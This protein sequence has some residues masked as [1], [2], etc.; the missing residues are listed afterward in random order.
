MSTN[1]KQANSETSDVHDPFEH[2]KSFIRQ[3]NLAAN[4]N[5]DDNDKPIQNERNEPTPSRTTILSV[6]DLNYSVKN[7]KFETSAACVVQ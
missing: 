4:D 6:E 5:K 1:N 7:F 2:F 3:A